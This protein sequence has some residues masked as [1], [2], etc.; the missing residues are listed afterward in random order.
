MGRLGLGHIWDFGTPHPIRLIRFQ[1]AP[2]VGEGWRMRNR[3]EEKGRHVH[4]L[5]HFHL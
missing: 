3:E 1:T 4:G 2:G 5:G